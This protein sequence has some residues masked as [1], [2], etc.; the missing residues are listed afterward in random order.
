M[1]H[2][3]SCLNLSSVSK[4]ILNNFHISRF[5]SFSRVS[6]LGSYTRSRVRR[7]DDMLAESIQSCALGICGAG[8][9]HCQRKLKQF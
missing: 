9:S 2:Y 3:G 6:F 8:T 5:S 1:G 4:Y 7:Y